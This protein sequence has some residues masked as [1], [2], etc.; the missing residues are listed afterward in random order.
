MKITK[1]QLRRIIK[2]ELSA[3]MTEAS[4]YQR[5]ALQRQ[6]SRK[7]RAEEEAVRRARQK[8]K[9]EEIS[10][11]LEAH[12]S[13]VD[14]ISQLKGD[15]ELTTAL[16]NHKKGNKIPPKVNRK[17]HQ[18]WKWDFWLDVA[19]GTDCPTKIEALDRVVASFFQNPEMIPVED[20]SNTQELGENI[21]APSPYEQCRREITQR[22]RQRKADAHRVAREET[23]E[24]KDY[25]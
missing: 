5:M 4:E 9:D 24:F 17:M 6:A 16:K 19:P 12:N 13:F 22:K 15:D 21:G 23:G 11:I 1:S 2:E 3:T 7:Q 18:K 25:E 20:T 14:Y 10:A 8:E